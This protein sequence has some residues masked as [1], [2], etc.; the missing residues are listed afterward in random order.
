[1]TPAVA[2]AISAP[3][4]VPSLVGALTT[5]IQ[6]QENKVKPPVVGGIQLDP[7]L[8]SGLITTAG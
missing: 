6:A 7:G 5:A 8:G 3:I 1:L 2:A 4:V